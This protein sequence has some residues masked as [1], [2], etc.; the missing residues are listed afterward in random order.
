[1]EWK[2]CVQRLINHTF[3]RSLRFQEKL[4]ELREVPYASPTPPIFINFLFDLTLSIRK[5]LVDYNQIFYES[6]DNE[7]C[8][9][10]FD[11]IQSLSS[12]LAE[13]YFLFLSP[14]EF[15][16]TIRNPASI[17]L[18]MEHLAQELVPG[19]KVIIYPSYIG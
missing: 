5:I 12:V 15:S 10:L 14:I 7:V 6:N 13:L 4:E 8:E 16:R 18:P 1:M 3:E 19:S 2:T 9:A 17:S 11:K